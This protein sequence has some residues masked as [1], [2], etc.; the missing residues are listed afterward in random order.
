MTFRDAEM[1]ITK[2]TKPEESLSAP[3]YS[4]EKYEEVDDEMDEENE[5]MQYYDE[6]YDI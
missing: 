1:V 2:L 6:E 5:D 3:I 4:S